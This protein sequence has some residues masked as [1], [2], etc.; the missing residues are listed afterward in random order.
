MSIE[1]SLTLITI[2][3]RKQFFSHIIIFVYVFVENS[4]TFLIGH[5]FTD[6]G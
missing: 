5:T 1:N 2:Q 3:T 6:G 4:A